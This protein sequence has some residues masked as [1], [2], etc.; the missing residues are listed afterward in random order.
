MFEFC[1]R[2]LGRCPKGDNENREVLYSYE[3]IARP[4]KAQNNCARI[5]RWWDGGGINCLRVRR[6]WRLSFVQRVGQAHGRRPTLSLGSGCGH[7]EV[8]V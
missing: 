2:C 5:V 3:L 4:I 8:E 1:E 7:I 6:R